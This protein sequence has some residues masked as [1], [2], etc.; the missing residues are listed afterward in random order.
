MSK[1]E[2]SYETL[3]TRVV[4]SRNFVLR[5]RQQQQTRHSRRTRR[6]GST[7]LFTLSFEGEKRC[8]EIIAFLKNYFEIRAVKLETFTVLQ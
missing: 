8:L 7:C 3:D 2:A 5:T 6:D 1:C 4:S